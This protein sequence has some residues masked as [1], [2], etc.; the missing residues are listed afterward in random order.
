MGISYG[1]I[2][3]LFT[4]ADEPAEPGRDLAAVGDRQDADDPLSRRHPQHR[5][6]ARV[7]EGAHPRRAARRRPTA[8]SRGRTSGSRTATRPARP[9]RPST[10]RPSNLLAKIRANSHYKPKVADPLAPIT[11]VTRSR[12]PT[13]WPASGPTS[14]RA[15][16]APTSPMQF[17]GT[18]RKWFT[19]T[20]GTHVDSL[21]PE[22]FNRWY[23]FLELYVA[24]QAPITDSRGL[25]GGRAGHL[26]GGD[27]HPRGDAAAGSDPAAADLRRA[28]WP[29][30]RSCRRSGSCSTTAPAARTRA[31]RSPASSSRSRASRFPARRRT[32]VVPR[33]EAARS[34]D[35]RRRRPGADAFKWNADARPPTDFTGDTAG[36]RRPVDRDA[37]V[38][39]GAAARGRA[40]LSYVSR[41]AD[42]GHDASSAPARVDAWVRSSAP[43]VDLQATISEVRPDGKETFVQN[44][45][46][47]GNER[48]LDPP[49]ARRSSRC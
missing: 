4:A 36:H 47:R 15:A 1:G 5:L 30:S 49:R 17:T 29:P 22:T 39:V 14:R 23:D 7:G 19:F 42:A 45:W 21:D 38:Q 26:P 28:R 37:A 9:T 31:S 34:A 8:A 33:R 40:R 3:Q 41:A 2:S 24:K 12:R 27:G 11:F 48:K 43:N 35:R 10:A 44:G 13:S 6:R 20:N 18:R 32:L 25:T 46:L 16:T